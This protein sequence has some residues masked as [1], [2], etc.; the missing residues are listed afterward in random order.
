MT[1][2]FLVATAPNAHQ[3]PAAVIIRITWQLA[4]SLKRADLLRLAITIAFAIPIGSA[5]SIE[6]TAASSRAVRVDQALD[7]DRVQPASALNQPNWAF[8][9]RCAAFRAIDGLPPLRALPFRTAEFNYA[10]PIKA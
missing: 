4:K 10:E 7:A 3:S 2:F 6:A 8:T 9:R 5:G 1:A